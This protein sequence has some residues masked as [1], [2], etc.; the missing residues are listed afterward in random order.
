[1][2]ERRRSAGGEPRDRVLNLG[3]PRVEA[4]RRRGRRPVVFRG[5]RNTCPRRKLVPK[6]S[7]IHLRAGQRAQHDQLVHVAQG[8]DPEH[9]PLELHQPPAQRQIVP[10]VR[11]QHELGAVDP[12]RQPNRRH[13][14]GILARLL[15]HRGEPPRLHREPHPVRHPIVPGPHVLHPLLQQ[16]IHRLPEPPQQLRTRRV[17]EIP[18]GVIRQHVRPREKHPRERRRLRRGDR[19]LRHAHEPEPR[20]HHEPF[21]GAR[22]RHVNSPVIEPKLQARDR[23]HAVDHE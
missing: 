12:L 20:W 23:G 10:L 19:L 8:S 16:H 5:G 14:P 2:L 15:R 21:L 13:R 11:R 1:M 6:V 9:L 4:P 17:R 22:H 3:L 7:Q 18:V